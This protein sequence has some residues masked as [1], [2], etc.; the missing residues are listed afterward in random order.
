MSQSA[1][2]KSHDDKETKTDP[3]LPRS[4]Y[5]IMY[6]RRTFPGTVFSLDW[7]GQAGKW[8]HYEKEDMEVR[9]YHYKIDRTAYYAFLDHFGLDR[10]QN[11]LP[12]EKVFVAGG[13]DLSPSEAEKFRQAKET[14]DFDLPKKFIRGDARSELPSEYV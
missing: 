11:E 12:M 1:S 8:L 4:R 2:A 5:S 6:H 10:W 14:D 7:D 3:I 13:R 9:W